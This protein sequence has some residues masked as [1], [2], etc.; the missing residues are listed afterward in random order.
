[1]VY[2]Y[3]TNVSALPDPSDRS[4]L[5]EALPSFRQEKI[6]RCA[7]VEDRKRSLG[8]GLLLRYAL[9]CHAISPDSIY[10]DNNGKPCAAG[11]W[12]SLSHSGAWAVC[13]VSER[14]VG[15][16]I[17]Q[18]AP[19]RERVIRRAFCPEEIAYLNTFAGE[20]RD[21]IFFRLWTMKESYFKMTGEGIRVGLSRV[22]LQLDERVR[23]YRDGEVIP[24]HF[25][26]YGLPGHCL[27]VCA[28]ENIFAP[29]AKMVD[30]A[31][32]LCR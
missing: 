1:M 4:D 30:A 22:A 8:A 19:A 2:T 11:V 6:L 5:F 15:C 12:F 26:E 7:Q 27:S 17:E 18:I 3:L 32:L 23:I 25:Y 10:L 16:D 24:C 28:H 29:A 31:V 14:E 21:R 9:L 13:A 20:A